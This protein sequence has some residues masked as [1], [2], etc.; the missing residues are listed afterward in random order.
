MSAA[1]EHLTA[2]D[3]PLQ[4]TGILNRI[5]KLHNKKHVGSAPGSPAGSRHTAF[6]TPARTRYITQHAHIP[7]VVFIPQTA[8]CNIEQSQWSVEP[9][10][11]RVQQRT[12]TPSPVIYDSIALNLQVCRSLRSQDLW[13]KP[14]PS[15]KHI[16]AG[17]A[18]ARVLELQQ[19][20][21]DKSLR[22]EAEAARVAQERASQL[23]KLRQRH[24][25]V[26][27]TKQQ[28]SERRCGHCYVAMF[29]PRD[30]MLIMTRM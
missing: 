9:A 15:L 29:M 18:E 20:L 22:H 3:R 8:E 19:G 24:Q 26:D 17:A 12:M 21:Q 27:A 13:C 7:S 5:Q 23:S 11:C 2:D 6:S 30:C 14:S 16:V 25:N 28:T 1:E 4:A 10:D